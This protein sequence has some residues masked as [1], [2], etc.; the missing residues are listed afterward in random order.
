MLAWKA[1]NQDV[2]NQITA[3]HLAAEVTMENR[4]RLE[5]PSVEDLDEKEDWYG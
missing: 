1:G 5:Q 4:A 3:R 2:N